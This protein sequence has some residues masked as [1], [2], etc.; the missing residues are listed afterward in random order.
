M[1]AG[2]GG[3]GVRT[4][5]R[6]GRAGGGV[7][8]R[9]PPEETQVAPEIPSREEEEAAPLVDRP[10][11]RE[12]AAAL[13]SPTH[14]IVLE[15]HR[16]KA[17]PPDAEEER[18]SRMKRRK[19][20]EEEEEDG[21]CRPLS[22]SPL[23][24]VSR[25]ASSA[26]G[27]GRVSGALSSSAL[28]EEAEKLCEQLRLR[29]AGPMARQEPNGVGMGEWAGEKKSSPEQGSK[30]RDVTPSHPLSTPR[31]S[32]PFTAQATQMRQLAESKGAEALE[33]VA[34]VSSALTDLLT[35]MFAAA[36]PELV[37]LLL[38]TT[39]EGSD[40]LDTEATPMPMGK[41]PTCQLQEGGGE[42]ERDE[43]TEVGEPKHISGEAVEGGTGDGGVAFSSSLGTSPEA[44]YAST[45][46]PHFLPRMVRE[47]EGLM[48]A[49]EE[50]TTFLRCG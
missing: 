13:P 42:R 10:H 32:Q 31:V 15:R 1:V 30:G 11:T 23:V 46:L 47:L 37:S 34:K 38:Q 21:R 16:E 3:Q 20:E 45:P 2:N 4:H 44:H 40:G 6:S 39:Q 29:H 43:K 8:A 12:E 26:G 28:Q 33:G 24:G 49:N 9:V 22:L 36:P 18:E 7:A 41:D 25:T 5:Q 48:R 27:G 17:L 35:K 50:C 19:G 14:D